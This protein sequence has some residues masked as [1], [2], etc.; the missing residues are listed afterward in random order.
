MNS[1]NLKNRFAVLKL[2][3]KALESMVVILG[4]LLLLTL[5]LL[6]TADVF[7]RYVL[8]DPIFGAQDI[9]ILFLI[10]I[11]ALSIP[12]TARKGLHIFLELL[13]PILKPVGNRI[14]DIIMRF[15]SAG[16]LGVMVWR[17][18][19]SGAEASDF[20]EQTQ[21][22][23]LSFEPFYYILAVGFTLYAI[24]LVL[25]AVALMLQEST[26]QLVEVEELND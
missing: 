14:A 20:G 9:S 5:T 10:S 4:G 7:M 18:I 11:V 22:L 8:N 17:L 15:S 25:E 2:F 6:I 13:T 23:K 3:D 19:H 16:V 21:L 1:E 24:N 12:Y 26:S